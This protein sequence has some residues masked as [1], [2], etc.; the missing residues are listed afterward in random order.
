MPQGSLILLPN[1][2]LICLVVEDLL[3]GPTLLPSEAV[4]GLTGGGWA[5]TAGGRK[6]L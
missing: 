6:G 5:V 2:G 1:L 3:L 4:A